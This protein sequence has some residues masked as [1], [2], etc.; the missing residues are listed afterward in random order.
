MKPDTNSGLPTTVRW[1]DNSRSY[2]IWMKVAGIAFVGYAVLMT[3]P[4]QAEGFSFDLDESFKVGLHQAFAN[5]SQFGKDFIYTYG[6]YGILQ[7]DKYFPETYSSLMLGR[8]FIGLAVGIGLWAMWVRCWRTR[9]ISSLFLLPFLFYFPNS[10]ILL[11]AFFT[12]V[13]VLPL[14]VY[15][16]VDEDGKSD[17]SPLLLFL[18]AGAAL[19]GL[20]KHTFLTLGVAVMLAIA[21]DRIGRSRRF[22]ISLV[23]YLGCLIGFW[24]CAG[25]SPQNIGLYLANASQIVKGF[26]ATMGLG[27]PVVEDISYLLGATSF[28]AL[29]WLATYRYRRRFDLLP[30]GVLALI[31]FLTFKG[32]FVRHDGHVLQAVITSIPIACL[33]SALLWSDISQIFW[34]PR[35][36]KRPVS[37]VLIAWALLLINAQFL[38]S[39]YTQSPYSTYYLGALRK[40]PATISAASQFGSKAA[41][42]QAIYQS[43]LEDIKAAISLPELSGTTDL[44]PNEV[45]A[46]LANG[47]TYRQRPVVQS[48]SAY[49]GKLAEINAAHLRSENAPDNIL[50]DVAAID[51]RWPSSEDGLSWPELLS[52]YDITDVTGRFLVLRRSPN[53][54]NYSLT[55]M[56]EKVVKLKDWV[57][58][59]SEDAVVWMKIDARPSLF[60]RLMSTLFK[61]P[62]LFLEAE[63]V[64]GSIERRRILVDVLNSGQLLS[65]LVIDRSEFAYLASSSW[66][67]SLRNSSVRRMRLVT[68]GWNRLAYPRRYPVAFSRLDFSH[69]DLSQISGWERFANLA[70][71]KQGQT[72]SA[73]NRRLEG[74]NGSDGK[75]VL[76]AHADT[77]IVVPL[78]PKS[79]KLTLGYG[80][81][82]EAWQEAEKKQP[83]GEEPVADGV[84][85]RVLALGSDGKANTLFSRW[86]D[87]HVN[88]GDRTEQTTEIDLMGISVAT[89]ALETLSGPTQN[90]RLDQA[91]WS[92]FKLE[93][94]NGAANPVD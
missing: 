86:I 39:S 64:D 65:P 30:V 9:R 27:G 52:R 18:V 33:Y 44:Y 57:D 72:V 55:L 48:F 32:A 37:S 8:L 15:F 35:W 78:P 81:L 12:V 53:A 49:T 6:P 68:E 83:E 50:F 62:P 29:V 85:F 71:L 4:W 59:P 46:V 22:P 26:S 34:R 2:S 41:A 51:R 69:Q 61:L 40:I 47:L 38:F 66:Q 67:E 21:T 60:G 63:L 82:E 25:Q 1:G 17:G 7:T 24:L 84:T 92:V 74:R 43:S 90:N 76:L 10:G 58:V 14:L 13:V 77:R 91:Y 93:T 56:N 94:A 31:L 70:K 5:S 88:E 16:Y 3:L 89:I 75:I 73:D 23:A 80:I 79:R 54:K 42:R 36:L 19:T 87:P 20:I 11:D 45:A 28:F